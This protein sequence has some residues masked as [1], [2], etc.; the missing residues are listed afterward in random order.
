MVGRRVVRIYSL[1]HGNL[2]S[3]IAKRWY[4]VCV[5]VLSVLDSLFT[6]T[7]IWQSLSQNN[8]LLLK[9]ASVTTKLMHLCINRNNRTF[10]P[11][12]SQHHCEGGCIFHSSSA[13]IWVATPCQF[14]CA[15]H[16]DSH[17][18]YPSQHPTT[19]LLL[20]SLQLRKI[21]AQRG[22]VTALNIQR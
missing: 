4:G 5:C 11:K 16:S 9:T 14:C 2:K 1:W 21:S 10:S 7:Y 15:G 17:L 3:L 8:F 19:S 22:Q 18:F 20:C 12:S 13:N 6:H